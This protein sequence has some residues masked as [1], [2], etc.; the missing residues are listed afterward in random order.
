MKSS[1]EQLIKTAVD[2]LLENSEAASITPDIIVERTRDIAHGHFSCNI[3][4]RLAKALKQSPRDIA[5]TI[6][7]ALPPSERVLKTEVAGP[8]FLNFWMSAAAFHTE[9]RA[10]YSK[11]E[12]YGHSQIGKGKK[13]LLEFVSANPTGPLHV[14][15]G[16][17]AAYGACVASLLKT[18][19]H[20]VH[21]EYY[22][23]D[24]GRQMDILALSTWLRFLQQQEGAEFTFP[25][26]AY[27][28]EYLLPIAAE[29]D[30]TISGLAINQ[31][32]GLFADLPDDSDAQLDLLIERARITLG[33]SGFEHILQLALTHILDDIR[34]DL[35]E[36]QVSIDEWFSEKSLTGTGAVQR[37]L[38]LLAKN[39]VTYE[40]D[41]AIWFRATDYGDEKDR[42]V[43]RDNGRSTYFASD[44]AYHLQKRER[45]FTDLIDIWGADHHG[46]IPRVR[47]G[48]EAMGQPSDCLQVELVQ[49]VALYRS[50]KKAQMSTRSGEFVTLRQLRK[51]VGND[52]ARLFFVMRSNEQHLDFDLDLATSSSNENPVYY[53]QYAHA[54]AC[55]VMRQLEERN[56]HWDSISA[57]SSLIHLRAPHEQALMLTL[58]RYPEIV[59]A[60]ALQKA[61]QHVV[62]YL[63][64]LAQEFHAYYNAHK[65]IVDD[66]GLRNARLMLVLVTRQVIRNGL[67]L[68]GVSAPDKM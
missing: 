47:A 16:R 55:S 17:H 54:R 50:G 41:G 43:V 32:D 67:S 58:T 5:N 39:N 1:I 34:D 59:E 57:D 25:T 11:G 24:A 53:L 68:L 56:L 12:V 26:S 49:F 9:I 23:N 36:F 44:I 15:H 61:P 27:Q 18:T 7:A 8:G 19:G 45:G 66:E 37:A 14:G 52:A 46:Y 42:V 28:G 65:F 38:D 6:I 10:M 60:A 21:T 64:E 4:M 20:S 30:N 31:I 3:A 40:K 35:G 62:H 13:V 2:T 48:M 33:D 63:K 51:E 22:V 29:L